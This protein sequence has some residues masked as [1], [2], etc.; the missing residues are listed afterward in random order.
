LVPGCH[1]PSHLPLPPRWSIIVIKGNWVL[2]P[3]SCI[4]PQAIPGSRA[5]LCTMTGHNGSCRGAIGIIGPS[6]GDNGQE[7]IRNI[8]PLALRVVS[9]RR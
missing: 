1:F 3:A 4:E 2:D 5:V 9:M 8:T 6:C 7:G